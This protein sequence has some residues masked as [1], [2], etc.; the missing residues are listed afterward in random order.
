M[1]EVFALLRLSISERNHGFQLIL[2]LFCGKICADLE[3]KVFGVG[4]GK[5][6]AEKDTE[7]NSLE[8]RQHTPAVQKREYL[9][10]LCDVIMQS[11]LCCNVK[12]TGLLTWKYRG[13]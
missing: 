9:P 13:Q 1:P 12:S 5:M 8:L 10:Q 4:D 11:V 3:R 7:K 2:S 6:I